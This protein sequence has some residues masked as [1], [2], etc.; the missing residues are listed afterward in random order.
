[1]LVC[2]LHLNR[3]WD[4]PKGWPLAPGHIQGYGFIAFQ[5]LFVSQMPVTQGALKITWWLIAFLKIT[6]CKVLCRG[7]WL[8]KLDSVVVVVVVVVVCVCLNLFHPRLRT[9]LCSL[10]F[11]DTS[12][13]CLVSWSGVCW[14]TLWFPLPSSGPQ[15]IRVAALHCPDVL[16]RGTEF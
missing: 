4:I 7:E 5:L 2:S 9:T 16:T 15:Q 13:H 6:T 1:M 3:V 10:L 12:C 11:Y 8:L 14:V